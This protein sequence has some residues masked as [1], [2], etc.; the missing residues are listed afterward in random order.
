MVFWEQ[1]SQNF[2]DFAIK[3]KNKI[4]DFEYEGIK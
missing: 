1:C 3:P 2:D 4:D